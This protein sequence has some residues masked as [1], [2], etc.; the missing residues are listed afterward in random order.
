M[1]ENTIR[2]KG[3]N[4]YQEQVQ[5]KANEP[6]TVA[7]LLDRARSLPGVPRR[8]VSLGDIYDRLENNSPR[9]AIICGSSDHPAHIMDE[10]VKLRFAA[11]IWGQGGVPFSF[12]VPVL[13]DGTAQSNIGMSYSLNSRNLL[14]DIVVNQMEA[15][16]YHSAVVLS[17]CDK[18]PFGILNGLANLDAVRQQRG[19]HPLHATFI[20]SHVLR[21]GTLPSGLR[22]E[23]ETLA[24][25]ARMQ[26]HEHL[27]Q[28]LDETLQYILQCSTNQAYQG[29][30]KRAVQLNLLTKTDH[31]RIEKELAIN[32][33]DSKGGICAFY[34]TGNTSRLVVSALGLTHPATELLVEPPDQNQVETV[35]RALFSI[36][37]KPDFSVSN[38][39]SK[40]IE[41]A[42][43]LHSCTGGSTN[44]MMHLVAC[45]L[46]SVYRFDLWDY[47]RIR[48]T[49]PIPDLFDYSLT[50]GRDMFALAQQCCSGQ[51]YGTE[52]IIKSLADNG[53]PMNLSSPTVTG[54][55]WKDR[56]AARKESELRKI[57]DNPIILNTPRRSISGIDVL[58]GNF[59]ESAILKVSGFSDQQ[60]R[61][62]DE[63]VFYVLYFENEDEA[64]AG[65]T[66]AHLVDS[67]RHQKSL[68]KEAL[69]AMIEANREDSDP[70]LAEANLMN[71]SNLFSMM[72][73]RRLFKVAVVIS[74]QGPEA[75]GMPEMFTPMHHINNNSQLRKLAILLSDGRFS[76]V[77]YGAAIG[78]MTP[79]AYKGGHL[80]F[81]KTGDML[82]LQLSVKR[83]ELL[84]PVRVRTGKLEPYCRSLDRERY[85][86]GAQ[87]MQRMEKRRENLSPTNRME[88][89][90]DA[91]QGV[92]PERIAKQATRKHASRTTSYRIRNTRRP[93]GPEKRVA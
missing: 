10:E 40:N 68:S 13:C 44:L 28:D 21:G 47:Q 25:T 45:M 89:V 2:I 84:D 22:K 46:Y 34:G 39:V 87:R 15:H 71:R 88:A 50:A 37:M 70:P 31:K 59:F 64:T 7:A 57:P 90:T 69:L 9:V 43:R 29:I 6:I 1:P 23:L 19:D 76:G 65:L 3:H 78:H 38:I 27:A 86:L 53:L 67:L 52:S 66:D 80:L 61:E 42:I 51:S 93:S 20:P 4:P 33:C 14:S 30:L 62:F 17:G 83:V 79:E 74:G 81:L 49:Q 91:S 26:R 54:T 5:G 18:S 35:T 41:N 11:S 75:Y 58:R 36:L 8:P 56:M 12:G 48:N 72:I 85:V 55:T 24:A 60:I 32:T 73:D 92:V 16:S 77:T 82:R 63:K